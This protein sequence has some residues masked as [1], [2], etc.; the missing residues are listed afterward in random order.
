M[1]YIVYLTTNVSNNKIYVG[2]HKTE[3][4]SIFDGYIGNS[5][6]IFESN[7]E[8]NNPKLPFHRAVKKYGYSSF[9]RETLAI[10]N[11]EK[12]ALDME[13]IIV[14]QKFIE[15][16]DTYNVTL[17]GGMPPLHNKLVYQYSL[18]G[19]YI[20]SYQAD[21]QLGQYNKYEINR[22]IKQGRTYKGYIWIRG[23]KLDRVP[24]KEGVVNKRR[25]IGQYTLE[26]QL[27]K[28]FNTL[29]EYR[30]YFPNVSK[31]LRGQANHCHNYTFKYIE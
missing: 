24:S 18:Q 9:K 29:R 8:L 11:T 2:V 17:G 14:D 10:F 22:S 25:K 23:E 13:A 6:N 16:E 19:E 15:R 30:Q 7:P 27:V 3:N 31:V 5:I 28:I 1:K 26:G 12:E 4:P 20:R 21:E